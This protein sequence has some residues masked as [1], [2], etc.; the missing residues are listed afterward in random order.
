[1]PEMIAESG[2]WK[3]VRT[4][5]FGLL[6]VG[7]FSATACFTFSTSGPE[8]VDASAWTWNAPMSAPNTLY[9]RNANG[10]VEVQ[11]STDGNVR[12][13]AAV[14]WKRGDPKRDLHFDAV[15]SG[16]NK[17]VCAIWGRGSCG[18]S[19][20]HS[21]SFS[22]KDR[23]LGHGT[24]ASVTLTVYVPTGVRVDALTSNGSVGIAATAPV[25]VRTMNGTIKVATSVGPVDAETV[26]GDVDVRMTTLGADGP[27][28][29]HSVNGS[30]SAY[31]PEKFDGSVKMET[32]LG[33]LVSD[34]GGTKSKD[35]SK[36]LSATIGAGGRSVDLGTVTGSAALHK[37]NANGTVTAP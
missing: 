7:A 15:N 18:V 28:R 19:D 14:R 34:F 8:K 31:L 33:E 1:M 37:L 12:V 4:G 29:A 30:V 21:T 5:A 27:V 32:V 16:N 25:T 35:D 26:N 13:T 3:A 10:P 23:F 6:A 17:V 2:R 36:N 11:P 24:D 9:I 20:Y 22:A